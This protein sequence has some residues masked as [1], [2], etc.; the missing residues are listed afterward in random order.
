[1]F[2]FLRSV[3]KLFNPVKLSVVHASVFIHALNSII[4]A[5]VYFPV[6]NSLK[7]YFPLRTHLHTV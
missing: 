5:T 2:F 4:Q 6:I 7:Y 1:M 3:Y